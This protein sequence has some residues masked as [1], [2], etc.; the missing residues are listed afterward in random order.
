M[1]GIAL[2]SPPYVDC[3]MSSN[4]QGIEIRLLEYKSQY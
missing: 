3:V 1:R 4:P 2:H